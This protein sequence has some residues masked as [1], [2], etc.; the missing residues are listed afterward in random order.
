VSNKTFEQ[1]EEQAVKGADVLLGFCQ[2][3]FDEPIDALFAMVVAIACVSKATNM[4]LSDLFI[5][6]TLAHGKMEKGDMQ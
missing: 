5:G 3:N 6:I 4:S 2:K 1:E